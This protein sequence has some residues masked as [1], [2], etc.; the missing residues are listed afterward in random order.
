MRLNLYAE[1]IPYFPSLVNYTIGCISPPPLRVQ[2]LFIAWS[3]YLSYIRLSL[4][5]LIKYN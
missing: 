4:F 2:K 1:I 3:D 5:I